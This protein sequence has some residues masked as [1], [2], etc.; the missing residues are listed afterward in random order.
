[1]KAMEMK[2]KDTGTSIT[3]AAHKGREQKVGEMA[4]RDII[5]CEK[6]GA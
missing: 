3:D 4:A 6:S 1:M 5:N 2:L